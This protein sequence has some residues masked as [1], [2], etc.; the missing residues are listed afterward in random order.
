MSTSLPSASADVE[1]CSVEL[2]SG[3]NVKSRDKLSIVEFIL[4]KA[5]HILTER[6]REEVEHTNQIRT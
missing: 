4:T 2:G 3:A 6:T 5:A 1:V